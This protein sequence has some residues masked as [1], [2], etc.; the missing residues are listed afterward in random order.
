MTKN[1]PINLKKREIIEKTKKQFKKFVFPSIGAMWFFSL[2]TMVDGAFVGKGVG[3]KAL[4]GVNIS[5]P[6]L[7]L[8]FALSILISVGSSNI[9]A[10]YRGR[11]E[12]HTA[13]GYFTLSLILITLLGLGLGAFAFFNLDFL[14]RFLKAEGEVYAYAYDYLWVIVPFSVFFM[15]SYNLEI[16]V[17]ADGHPKLSVKVGI[18][19]S[20]TNIVLDYLF[21]FVFDYGIKGAAVATGISQVLGTCIYLSHFL[22]AKANLKFRRINAGFIHIFKI[23]KTGIPEALT[24][25]SIGFTTF[26]Y[27]YSIIKYLG[28]DYITTYSI[29]MYVNNLVINTMIAINQG[30]QP[31]VSFHKGQEN[32]TSLRELFYLMVR[33]S[34]IF[35]GFF[36]VICLIFSKSLVG[37][38]IDQGN[39]ELF[40]YS[41]AKLR[42]FSFGFIITGL[43]IVASG[44]LTAS[45]HPREGLIVSIL[46]G[47]INISLALFIL[48]KALGPEYIWLATIA[49]ELVTFFMV[50]FIFIRTLGI[51]LKKD[52]G[53][54]NRA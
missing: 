9:I 27:N 39:M 51:S 34:L 49:S 13:S 17:K 46:R 25:L 50:T 2:Y 33:T 6:Y 31:L 5:M 18:I 30:S 45:K 20:L 14:L 15:L 44:Y 7:S 48:P 29:I 38:F 23:I 53:A 35:G 10:Y 8:L 47:Y 52:L 54:F 32:T 37:I 22:F 28:L 16:L 36:F 4:A 12:D 42:I 1:C 11:G 19:A 26:L 43:S 24:E 40:T 21:V 41:V 3:P